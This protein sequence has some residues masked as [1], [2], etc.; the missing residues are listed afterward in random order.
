MIQGFNLNIATVF[1]KYLTCK[2][3]Q[4]ES[5]IQ[6]DW[7]TAAGQAIPVFFEPPKTVQFFVRIV[8]E[9]LT[10]DNNIKKVKT[11]I[12]SLAGQKYISDPLYEAEIVTAF[13]NNITALLCVGVELSLDQTNWTFFVSPGDN[14]MLYFDEQNI[15]VINVRDMQ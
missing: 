15:N 6:Q 12:I 9:G 2:T 10:S 8:V 11:V 14:G 13:N 1:Y 7:Y 3:V 5:S 4:T